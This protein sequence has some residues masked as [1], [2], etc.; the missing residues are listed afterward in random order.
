MLLERRDLEREIGSEQRL[1]LPEKLILL[2]E[3]A[4]WLVLNEQSD[5]TYQIALDRFAHRLQFMPDVKLSAEEVVRFML[6]RSG[7]LREPIPGRIDF[8]HR[9]FFQ[10]YLAAVEVVELGN[11]PMLVSRA[12]EDNWREVVVLAAGACH[13]SQRE[14]LFFR[15]LIDRGHKDVTNRHT[16]WLVAVA[17]VETAREVSPAI[18]REIFDCLGELL[19]PQN[20]SEAKKALSSAGE[21]ALDALEKKF[22][23]ARATEVAACIRT[24]TLVG[25]EASLHLLSNYSNDN[26]I[27][28][29]RALLRAWQLHDMPEQYAETVLADAHLVRGDVTLSDASLLPHVK[30]YL[31]KNLKKRYPSSCATNHSIPSTSATSHSSRV[32][33]HGSMATS[34]PLTS[35]KTIPNSPS[36]T[37]RIANT[38][39]TSEL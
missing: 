17:C 39:M 6:V 5:A 2:Q 37:L 18:R 22:K 15:G 28:V 23:S 19:P 11:I 31:K 34:R 33:T 16:L 21:L 27:T 36:S 7:L 25:G 26:R 10:E 1:S 29:Q 9:T 12:A 38:S 35:L 14:V 30:K 3:F 32:L 8:I 4:Y 24:A 20:M 13:R